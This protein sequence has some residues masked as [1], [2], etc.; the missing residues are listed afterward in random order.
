MKY[1]L[2]TANLPSRLG[3]T[4]VV[5]AS[6]KVICHVLDAEWGHRFAEFIVK[7][8]N[9]WHYLRA[10]FRPYRRDD[11]LNEVSHIRFVPSKK[12]QMAPPTRKGTHP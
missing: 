8:A 6:G 7:T 4:S 5:D 2:K 1:P 3:E 10:W 11:W 9:R 12:P